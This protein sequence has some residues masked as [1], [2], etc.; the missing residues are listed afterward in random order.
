MDNSS[1]ISLTPRT[2]VALW[3]GAVAPVVAGFATG[4]LAAVL[5]AAFT[6]GCPL[7]VVSSARWPVRA[8]RV[9]PLYFLALFVA[10]LTA[11]EFNSVAFVVDTWSALLLG[12]VAIPAGRPQAASAS[13][14]RN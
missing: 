9:F 13:P 5:G 8:P 2:S 4:G 11:F 14:S 6:A 12:L 7:L 10:A 3:L 1:R